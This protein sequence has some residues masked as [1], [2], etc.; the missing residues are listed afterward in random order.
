MP[1]QHTLSHPDPFL[2]VRVKRDDLLPP[3]AAVCAGYELNEWRCKQLV[4]HL[5]EWL[6][7]FV[8]T[9]SER[10]ALRAHN[11][12]AHVAQAAR[13]IYTSAKYQRRGE[14]GELLLHAIIR[15]VFETIP[16]IS[17]YYF[18]DSANDT[19]KGFDAVHVVASDAE[20]QLWLGEVKFYNEISRAIT[21]VV[22]ELKQH[23]DRDYL[24]GEFTA[25][26][27]KIDPNWKHADRLKKLLHRNTPL[28][29]I[30]DAVC[31]PVLL[32]Y[33]SPTIGAHSD[34]TASFKAAFEQEVLAHQATFASKALPANL[35][36]HLFLLPLRSK[37]ELMKQFD[38]K[39]K[40]WQT[41]A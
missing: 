41:I 15:Q 22:T 37:E 11:A 29:E 24:R 27:H 8:L 13:A 2:T 4:S 39:L 20:L 28:D 14:P 3:L 36:I 38:E 33:D 34:I 7:E 1:T 35:K 19:V 26:T 31:I 9:D 16:A 6:P 40:L 17:K 30:F 25:I 23:S 21:D 12:V 32:T 5:I 18:K 10:D